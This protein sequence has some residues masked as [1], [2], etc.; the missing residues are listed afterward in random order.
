MKF[1]KNIAGRHHYYEVMKMKFE[2]TTLNEI[3]NYLNSYGKFNQS[4]LC[5]Q[6]DFSTRTLYSVMHE[7]DCPITFANYKKLI[8][9]CRWLE[10]QRD[11][12]EK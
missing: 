1:K 9:M 11:Y 2:Y 3:S 12:G 8:E 6:F 5:R 10:R 4:A 7:A